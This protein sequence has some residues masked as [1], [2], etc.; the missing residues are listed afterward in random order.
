MNIITVNLQLL[1]ILS[2]LHTVFGIYFYI[3]E[4]ERKCFI[5][6]V[7]K[8]TH[9]VVNYKVELHDPQNDGNAISSLQI[10]MQ[11]DVNDPESKILLSRVYSLEGR[12][13]FTSQK[14]GEHAICMNSNSTAWFSGAQ[15]KV[16]LHIQVGEHDYAEMVKKENLSDL[17]LRIRQLLDQVEQISKEQE[18]QRDKEELFRFISEWT[19][20]SVFW[21]SLVQI[22]ILLIMGAWQMRHLKKFF[23]AKKIV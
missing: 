15:L 14:N 8:D 21:W 20:S 2:V 6:D 5:E 19:N 16:N 18:Y 7:P 11:V 17:Q 10:G 13:S 4:T 23:V 3:G 22:V 12:I 9:I 1:L